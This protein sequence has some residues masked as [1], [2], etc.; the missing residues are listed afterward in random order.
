MPRKRAYKASKYTGNQRSNW[1]HYRPLYRKSN[2]PKCVKRHLELYYT[3]WRIEAK[4]NKI[5]NSCMNII[6]PKSRGPFWESSKTSV[7]SSK[8]WGLSIWPWSSKE[9]VSWLKNISSRYN[10]DIIKSCLIERLDK[11]WWPRG[12]IGQ[13]WCIFPNGF[14]VI[15]F[16]VRQKTFWRTAGTWVH[17]LISSTYG[18]SNSCYATNSTKNNKN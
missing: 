13:R 6:I 8:F 17:I 3:I 15:E 5:S 10:V 9:N 2:R 4:R 16:C 14:N 11:R 1:G 7:K 12:R 18:G